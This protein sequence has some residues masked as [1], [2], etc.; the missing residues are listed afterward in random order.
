[1]AD[2]LHVDGKAPPTGT[3]PLTAWAREP[4]DTL[5]RHYTSEL[6]RRRDRVTAYASN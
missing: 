2:L 4:A 5:G 1:M 3:T 6:A